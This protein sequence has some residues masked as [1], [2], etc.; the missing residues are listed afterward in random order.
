MIPQT[1]NN[2]N[3]YLNSNNT[4]GTYIVNSYNMNSNTSNF[5]R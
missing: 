1:M 5:N 3:F 4:G 2:N